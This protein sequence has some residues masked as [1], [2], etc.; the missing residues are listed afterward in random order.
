MPITVHFA[1]GGKRTFA[2]VTFAKRHSGVFVL[3]DARGEEVHKF[4]APQVLFG[5]VEDDKGSLVSVVESSKRIERSRRV[6]NNGDVVT[7]RQFADHSLFDA[8]FS[9]LTGVA[10]IGV[11]SG[12]EKEAQDAADRRIA[13]ER[14]HRCT[15]AC[16][17][18]AKV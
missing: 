18:W 4:D 12:T 7:I 16:S 9:Y 5:V 15:E 3:S 2:N 1:D 10:H 6:H 13:D 17:S 14:K 8:D 11:L